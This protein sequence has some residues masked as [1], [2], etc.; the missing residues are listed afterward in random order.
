MNLEALKLY[1]N[2]KLTVRAD[3]PFTERLINICMHRGLTVC[4]VKKPGKNRVIF[5]TDVNSYKQI[6]TPARHT[7]SHVRI[8]KRSGLPF[9]LKR[10][11]HRKL[12]LGG[13]AVLCAMLIYCST[14]IMGITVFGNSRIDTATILHEL[15]EAGLSV[16]VKTSEIKSDAIRNRLMTKI[17]DLAWLGINANG[18]HVYIEVV[19]R[20]E[21]EKGINKD[22]APCNLVASRDGIIEHTEIREG[23][24]L[25]KNG[26]GVAEGDVL[27]SGIVDNAAEGFRF[28]RAR[29]DVYAETKYSKTKSYPLNYTEN[30]P[31]GKSKKRYSLTVLNHTLPL[32]FGSGN[33]YAQ[34]E[35]SEQTREMRLPTDLLPSLFVKCDEYAETA[36]HSVK[37]TPDEAIETGTAELSEE[38]KSELSENTEIK[39]VN[40]SHTLNE[41]GEVEVTVELVC[42]E[43]IAEPSVIEE[44]LLDKAQSIE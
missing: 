5:C 34:A 37:R 25:V 33:P 39:S 42:R 43:N 9:I 22:D 12:A 20:I 41:H 29:G 40:V 3:G 24:T 32:F 4:D 17:D 31:T 23:Q 26:S 2:G 35:H 16:G 30:T 8:I 44:P 18:S 10:F 36:S 1:L 19:E 7:K 6:R 14:H 38:L 21:K 11:R 15:S 27:V 13:V 28:V